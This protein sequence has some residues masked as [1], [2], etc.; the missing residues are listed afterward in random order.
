MLRKIGMLRICR[1]ISSGGNGGIAP[2]LDAQLETMLSD[3][4]GVPGEGVSFEDEPVTP[5]E[6]EEPAEAN[7][8]QVDAPS[9]ND[10]PVD[11]DE[12]E[13][14]EPTSEEI[15]NSLREQILALSSL[16][17]TK[18]P[19]LQNVQATIAPASGE[20][21]T[22]ESAAAAVVQEF[23]TADELD[24]LI[25]EPALINLAFQ[26]SQAQI[27]GSVGNYVQAEITKQLLV[28]QAVQDFYTVNEDLKPYAKFVQFVMASVEKANPSKNYGEIFV[29]TANE[30]RKRLGLAK[31][32]APSRTV[33]ANNGSQK[34]AFVGS[35]RG[36]ARPASQKEF[37][38]SNAK[39]VM[40]FALNNN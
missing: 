19:L 21:Q 14:V 9:T 24:R 40:D 16:D 11:A 17:V 30:C 1:D 6:T 5:A 3:L 7:E 36:N 8:L 13:E 38:D 15:I 33:Q 32:A 27:M 39:D 23:L 22:V 4:N 28:N 31:T 35:K 34:P 12:P 18:D 2:D 37:F 29:D 10:E 26:R 25:D 20:P